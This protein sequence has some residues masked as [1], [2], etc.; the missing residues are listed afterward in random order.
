M[1]KLLAALAAAAVLAVGLTGTAV[2]APTYI[3]VGGVPLSTQPDNNGDA[4][5]QSFIST[6]FGKP[7]TY[8]SRVNDTDG[9][10]VINANGTMTVS[11]GGNVTAGTWTWSPVAGGLNANV[12]LVHAGPDY[13]L[14]RTTNPD[15][16]GLNTGSWNNA[17]NG[18]V[19]N[20]GNARGTSFV[21][22]FHVTPVPAALPL[23]LSALAG[24]LGL[25][26]L[27]SRKA[28]AAA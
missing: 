17:I 22:L 10:S 13:A 28:A 24:V 21:A 23:L 1:R 7:A 6:F 2:A 19:N 5:L 9:T 11:P 4:T 27:R 18:L 25:R 8:L 16:A 12:F 15:F 26:H 3:Q 14:Y 20:R